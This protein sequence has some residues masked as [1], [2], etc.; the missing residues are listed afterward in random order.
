MDKSNVIYRSIKKDEKGHY[1]RVKIVEENSVALLTEGK[2]DMLIV[3][4]I[5]DDE[6]FAISPV[7]FEKN[8]KIEPSITEE[9][10][11]DTEIKDLIE[12]LQEFLKDIK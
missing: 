2:L 6:L 10:I 3:K 5:S 1:L 9:V 4:D 12:V 7:T 8:F 11:K